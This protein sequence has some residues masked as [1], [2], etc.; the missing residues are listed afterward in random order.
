MS[1]QLRYLMRRVVS[2]RELVRNPTS[3]IGG[4]PTSFIRGQPMHTDTVAG[5]A[6]LSSRSKVP[7]Y[8]RVGSQVCCRVLVNANEVFVQTLKEVLMQTPVV[9]EVGSPF[10]RMRSN[11]SVVVDLETA[12]KEY[13]FF[14]H[15]LGNM[16]LHRK[17]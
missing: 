17:I 4:Q 6:N 3:F 2:K 8:D 15:N 9:V 1:V 12:P 13:E 16:I 5:H 14:M 7:K 11:Q 10:T